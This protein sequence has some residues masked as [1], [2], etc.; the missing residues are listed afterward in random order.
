[1]SVIYC[2]GH[3][4]GDDTIA[5]GNQ[6]ADEAAKKTAMREFPAGPL[7]WEEFLI[8]P[9]KPHYQSEEAQ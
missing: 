9:R 5:R 7:L 2:L 3:Q 1:M 8:P 6:A 4:K